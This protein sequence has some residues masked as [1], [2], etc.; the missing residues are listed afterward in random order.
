MSTSSIAQ[1]KVLI[2]DDTPANIHVLSQTLEPQGYEIFTASQGEQGLTLATRVMP[3]VILLDVVMPGRSGYAICRELKHRPETRDIPVLFVT[4][5]QEPDDILLG[6]QAGATDYLVQPFRAE[7]VVARVKA[8]S[9]IARL[10]RELKERNRELEEE[11]SRRRTAEAERSRVRERLFVLSEEASLRWGLESLVGQSPAMRK[12]LAEIQRLRQF[13][14]TN[15]LITGESG[16][17]KELVA[18]ALHYGGTR[19]EA[20]FVPV[21]CTAIP[22]DLAESILFGHVKG[23]FTG[24]TSDRKGC[25]E[26]ADSGTLFLDEIGDMDPMLQA[27]LLRVLEDGEYTPVGAAKAKRGDVRVVA[28]TNTDLQAKIATGRFREDLYFRLARYVVRTPSLRERAADIPTIA[29]HFLVQLSSEMGMT[30]PVLSEAALTVLI[31]H[32]FPGSVRELKNLI[33]RAL[34]DSGGGII[35]PEHLSIRPIQA[36]TTASAGQAAAASPFPLNVRDAE[37]ELME[38]ALQSTGGNVVEAA[39]LL[40]VHRSSI[41]RRFENQGTKSHAKTQRR[42]D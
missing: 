8:H 35:E 37:R 23:A 11:V 38:R 21:N 34:I 22:G 5:R 14:S 19:K 28:A 36:P 12:V 6:F 33:E 3:D 1:R 20:P 4:A 29:A 15:V 30:P 10:T 25:F 32:P 16:T 18:R 41:Y 26:R 9:E 7:E 42:K 17:G 13:P 40:G 24:A 27:K 31:G 2:I 39:R